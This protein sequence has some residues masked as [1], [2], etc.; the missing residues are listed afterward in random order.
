M[1]WCVVLIESSGF[2]LLAGKQIG[3]TAEAAKL[4]GSKKKDFFLGFYFGHM[5][6]GISIFVLFIGL[7]HMVVF[8]S[9]LKFWPCICAYIMIK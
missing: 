2:H 8:A 5:Y 7:I 9:L 1:L 3:R 6:V 4:V